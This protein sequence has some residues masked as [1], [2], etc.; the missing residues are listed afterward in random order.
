MQGKH[1][2]HW[3]LDGARSTTRST[4]SLLCL[5]DSVAEC[6]RRSAWQPGWDSEA[7]HTVGWPV[8]GS[9][10]GCSRFSWLTHFRPNPGEAAEQIGL[11]ARS[12]SP[13][14]SRATGW[15]AKHDLEGRRRPRACPPNAD[16]R[17]L[18]GS[19]YWYNI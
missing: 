6:S 17:V 5:T 10:P 4:E 15:P 8:P 13:R 9:P 12:G 7:A 3:Q 18:P 19:A 2:L 16:E 11:G 1:R 14:T